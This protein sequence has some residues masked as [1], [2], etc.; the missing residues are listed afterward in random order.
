MAVVERVIETPVRYPHRDAPRWC[1]A[2]SSKPIR[3]ELRNNSGADDGTRT[4]D[5]NLG[6]VVL[7]QLS[8][9]RANPILA[10]SHG[11]NCYSTSTGVLM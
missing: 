4:R 2:R 11:Q 7:Y 1:G 10:E 6:K 8:H 9:V 5:P 3:N